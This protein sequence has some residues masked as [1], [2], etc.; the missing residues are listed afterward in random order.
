MKSESELVSA[1]DENFIASFRKLAEHCAEGAIRE[2]RGIFAFA[3][4]LPL[5]L[6]NGTVVTQPTT[7]AE[8]EASLQW[9]SDRS[10][11]HRAW[12]AEDLVDELGEIP[13]V[14]G[15]QRESVPYPGMVL[16]PPP[17][18]PAPSA[19]VTVEPVADTGL[20]EFVGVCIEGGL[21]LDLAQRLF[22]PSFVG[23]PEVQL[24]VGRLDGRP[25]G[26]SIAIRSRSASGIY[27]VG[28]LVDARRHG[29][30]RALTWAAAAA[31]RAWGSDV[32]VLQSSPM[33]LPMYSDMG[34]R[35]VSP[36]TTF[37]KLAL[38]ID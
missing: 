18:A 30:G 36:Y 4:G 25:V 22:P 33:A 16:H 15:L 10:I 2:S 12:I 9:V 19:E 11:A 17:D 14:H 8:L 27:N 34:F 23:D 5:P 7:P 29:I 21:P 35:T 24:F 26:T 6:F 32:I 20:D 3:T 28:T 37:T 38:T 1:A 13:P 31:G